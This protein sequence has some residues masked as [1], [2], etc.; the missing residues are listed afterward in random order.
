MKFW[1]AIVDKS[2]LGS[3]KMPLQPDDLPPMVMSQVS[4]PPVVDAE[5]T[6]LK[7]TSMA[8]Q[9]RQ[10]GAQALDLHTFIGTVSDA[11]EYPF[12][13]PLST[14]TCRSILA[15]ELFALLH[16]WLDRME[17]KQ[18]VAEPELIPELLDIAAAKKE[19]RNQIR[20]ICGKR[21]EWLCQLN[22]AW[23]FYSSESDVDALWQTGKPDERKEILRTLRLQRDNK[24]RTLLQSTW[25][26]EGANE[27]AAFLELFKINVSKADMEW[28]ESLKEKA[29]KVNTLILELLK[30]IPDSAI[31]QT[32]WS[33]VKNAV[34]I[35]TDKALLGMIS[36]TYIDV[37]ETLSVPE[38]IFK[39]GIENLSS[40]KQITDQQ[41]I[42]YQLISNVPPSYWNT[43]L[44]TTTA[45][46]I[47]L[48]QKNKK[49]SF[50]IPAWAQ[51]A[52]RF[53]DQTWISDLLTHAEADHLV[54][55]LIPLVQALPS[56][57]REQFVLR[58]FA[59]K[60]HEFVTLMLEQEQ[61]WSL[62][63]ARTILTFTALEV[64]AY[65]RTFYKS[66]VVRIPVQLVNEL[67][68]FTPANDQKKP[69]W[70][71]QS[72]ELYRLL[73]LK[74]QILQSI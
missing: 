20:K 14:S 21:G 24:A 67:D 65:N 32:Y 30:S 66:A 23:N 39:T 73:D 58:F 31:V 51:A 18:M 26:V 44:N 63:I 19:L 1:N 64:Y 25:S 2:L 54:T 60:P 40:N 43:Q 46:L 61:E 50:Y 71:T 34:Q 62:P 28:L 45:T 11:E 70:K 55:M 15:E 36:K 33:T 8:Y 57:N 17:A 47:E 4:L 48:A 29:Q 69:Y 12:A 35:K 7:L 68:T 3:A 74:K 16:V 72:D 22:P 41:H 52:V 42:L 9:Y 5:D 27:K 6:F 53:N 13:S 49:S 10:A 59:R 37:D 38:T 56:G